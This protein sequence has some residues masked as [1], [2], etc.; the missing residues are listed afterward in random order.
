MW[1]GIAG[2]IVNDNTE[3]EVAVSVHDSVYSTDFASVVLPYDANDP[4]RNAQTI[5]QYILQ[6]L[7][8]F[9]V[10]H[11]CKFLGAGI[12]LTLLREVSRQL[13]L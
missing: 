3:F 12:T 8:R 7:R 10:E 9:S 6:V 13:T 5:E 1:A 11:L 2:V 4:E